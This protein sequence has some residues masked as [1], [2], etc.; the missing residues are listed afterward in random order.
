MNTQIL[1]QYNLV[2]REDDFD[3]RHADFDIGGILAI[4]IYI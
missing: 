1:Q 3:G 2:F 4:Y